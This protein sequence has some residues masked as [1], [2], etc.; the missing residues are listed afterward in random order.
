[1]ENTRLIQKNAGA[2]LYA[3]TRQTAQSNPLFENDQRSMSG[4]DYIN[5]HQRRTTMSC[6]RFSWIMPDED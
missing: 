1:M 2:N 4:G 5:I 6:G 3:K